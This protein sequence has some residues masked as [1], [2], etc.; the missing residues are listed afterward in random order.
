MLLFALLVFFT[1]AGITFANSAEAFVFL[2]APAGGALSPFD[3]KPIVTDLPAMFFATIRISMYGGMVSALPVVTGGTLWVLRDLM[4]QRFWRF[5]AYFTL[6]SF[7]FFLTGVTFVYY[8]S[9][10]TLTAFFLSWNASVVEHTI[11]IDSYMEMTVELLWLI[12]LVFETPLIMFVLSKWRVVSYQRFKAL[13]LYSIPSSI[14][15]AA[16]LTPSID[17]LNMFMVAIPL[18]LLYQVGV[19]ASWFARPENGNWLG[20]SPIVP[21]ISPAITG[22]EWVLSRIGDVVEYV[23]VTALTAVRLILSFI[24]RNLK[25]K[26]IETPSE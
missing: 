19:G 13:W 5:M 12:G 1:G 10:P 20:L 4:P 11:T 18:A 24:W 7:G 22:F 16:I 6:F 3:G 21:Y 14:I 26:K 2:L 25:W 15:L 17:G 8:V 23:V 9:L